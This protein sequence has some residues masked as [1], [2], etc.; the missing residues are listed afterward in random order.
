MWAGRG[1]RHD[2]EHRFELTNLYGAWAALETERLKGRAG[3]GGKAGNEKC[4]PCHVDPFNCGFQVRRVYRLR[5]QAE[6][7]R[8][9]GAGL[10]LPHEAL[11]YSSSTHI[12][13]TWTLAVFRGH[14]NVLASDHFGPTLLAA[15]PAPSAVFA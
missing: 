3:Q 12:E 1:G 8:G 5:L 4:H 2:G 10:G 11:Q 15:S 7:G 6:G 14:Y 13:D 9:G